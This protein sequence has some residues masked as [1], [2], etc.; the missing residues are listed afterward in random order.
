MSESLLDLIDAGPAHGMKHVPGANYKSFTEMF[1][2]T[3]V[4]AIDYLDYHGYMHSSQSNVSTREFGLAPLAK[5]SMA[6]ILWC[7]IKAVIDNSSQF[8]APWTFLCYTGWSKVATT[9]PHEGLIIGFQSE[10]DLAL[11]TL[12]DL[13]NAW[14]TE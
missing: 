4:V 11:Y 5:H 8:E 2:H 6:N 13:R 7:N 1:R 9:P 14:R 12:K 3:E 10:N